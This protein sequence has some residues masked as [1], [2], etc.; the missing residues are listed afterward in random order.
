MKVKKYDEL[1]ALKG[2]M[3]EKK[4]T[5]RE[6]SD[7]SG[8]SLSALNNKIN[9]YSVFNIDELSSIVEILDIDANEIPKYFFPSTLRIAIKAEK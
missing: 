3:T 1:N 8:I 5:Y 2:L 4:V 6:L 9:G 7:K